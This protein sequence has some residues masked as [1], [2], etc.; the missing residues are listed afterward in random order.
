ML[1]SEAAAPPGLLVTYHRN[2]LHHPDAGGCPTFT[3]KT[4]CMLSRGAG[5]GSTCEWDGVFVTDGLCNWAGN[6]SAV[7]S[8]VNRTLRSQGVPELVDVT[9]DWCVHCQP[10]VGGW[11]GYP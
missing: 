10:L 3:N 2:L 1:L 8:Y 5:A 9:I 4:F 6:S 7:E 11:N